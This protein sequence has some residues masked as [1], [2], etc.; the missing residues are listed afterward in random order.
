M[1]GGDLHPWSHKRRHD[2]THYKAHRGQVKRKSGVRET[3]TTQR[4]SETHLTLFNIYQETRKWGRGTSEGEQ[5]RSAF[6]TAHAGIA[7]TLY[8]NTHHLWGMWLH[9]DNSILQSDRGGVYVWVCVCVCARYSVCLCVE[10]RKNE[11]RK[12]MKAKE[13][14]RN[15]AR[16]L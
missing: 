15:K 1:H 13:R 6:I 14:E 12:I 5:M 7:Q 4:A 11:K 2:R 16:Q 8:F 10:E 9:T 3:I